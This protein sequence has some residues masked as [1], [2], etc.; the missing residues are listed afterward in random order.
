MSDMR[1]Y[2]YGPLPAQVSLVIKDTFSGTTIASLANAFTVF[3]MQVI[4]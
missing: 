4:T 3:E 2:T 1:Q